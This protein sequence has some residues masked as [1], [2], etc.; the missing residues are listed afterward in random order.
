MLRA[1]GEVHTG[2]LDVSGN[3]PSCILK[4]YPGLAAAGE[5]NQTTSDA[6][7][8]PGQQG[9]SRRHSQEHD[10]AICKHEQQSTARHTLHDCGRRHQVVRL[11]VGGQIHAQGDI[12]AN[13][14]A[15]VPHTDLEA[16]G[17]NAGH[18]V[19]ANNARVHTI[20]LSGAVA[21]RGRQGG[22]QSRGDS[23]TL[24]SVLGRKAA[25][26]RSGAS[27]RE[28]SLDLSI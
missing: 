3:N 7:Q 2:R 23:G 15:Y 17:K 4:N 1:D 21:I 27:K 22:I 10:V 26:A 5:W 16:C 12:S 24:G 18:V 8:E 6:A 19:D 13:D 20:S 28:S 11:N 25:R 14:V 9:C